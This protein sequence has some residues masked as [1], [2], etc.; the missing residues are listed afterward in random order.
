M[1]AGREYEYGELSVLLPAQL[2]QLHPLTRLSVLIAKHMPK[3]LWWVHAMVMAEELQD[4]LNLSGGSVHCWNLLTEHLPCTK[5][6][7]CAPI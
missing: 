1:N 7:V 3:V 6:L 2:C 4:R 5:F